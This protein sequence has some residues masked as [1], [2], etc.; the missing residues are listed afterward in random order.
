MK[1]QV[2]KKFRLRLYPAR[3]KNLKLGEN[4]LQKFFI[5]RARGE[6]VAMKDFWRIDC[7]LLS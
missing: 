1:S 7:S 4:G 3:T 2:I 5:V 6:G